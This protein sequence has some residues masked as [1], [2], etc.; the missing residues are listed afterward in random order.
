MCTYTLLNNEINDPLRGLNW[1]EY[2][3]KFQ[4]VTGPNSSPCFFVRPF[5]S[6]KF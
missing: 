2:L 4:D 3:R 5:R 1:Y 6:V